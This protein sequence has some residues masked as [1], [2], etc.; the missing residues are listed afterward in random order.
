M[1]FLSMW[2]DNLSLLIISQIKLLIFLIILGKF[3]PVKSRYKTILLDSEL[4][5]T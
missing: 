1:L 5:T 2:L 3:C 4:L